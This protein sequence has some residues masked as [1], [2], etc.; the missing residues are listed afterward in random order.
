MFL[1]QSIRIMVFEGCLFDLLQIRLCRAMGIV[2]L[3][4]Y[5]L[6]CVLLDGSMWELWDYC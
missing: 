6:E 1:C 5:I 4:M 2:L 3:H